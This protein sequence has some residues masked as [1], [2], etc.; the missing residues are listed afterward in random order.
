MVDLRN[1]GY[2]GLPDLTQLYAQ[3]GPKF[4]DWLPP[5]GNS[6]PKPLGLSLAKYQHVLVCL[7]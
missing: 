5:A 6:L 4:P 7:T 2:W 1:L 3:L